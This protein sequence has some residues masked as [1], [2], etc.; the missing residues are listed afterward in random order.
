MSLSYSLA[1]ATLFR[2]NAETAHRLTLKTL[3]A[4]QRLHVLPHRALLDRSPVTYMGLVFPNRV[5]LA[6][7]FD[8]NGDY[9]DALAALGFGFLEIGTVTPEAQ[10][11]NPR[12]RLFRLPAHKA[13]INR[14]GFNN[15][16]VAYL[17]RRLQK[18]HYSGILG[19]NIGKNRST[20]NAR[21]LEDYQLCLQAVYPYASYIT[22]NVSSPNTQ[23]LR[24]LQA[25]DALGDLLQGLTR[26]G[27]QL[28][29]QHGRNVPLMVKIAPDLDE[30][31]IISICRAVEMARFA[32]IVATNTTLDR[33][34]IA[35]HSL[36]LQAGG[37]SGAPLLER[38]NTVLRQVR[39]HLDPALTLIGSGGITRGIDARSKQQAGADLVQ[40]Y[41]GLVYV[42]PALIA[43]IV[44]A[45]MNRVPTA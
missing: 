20:P 43:E 39:K 16:G 7:G 17:V 3:W 23:G 40:V 34:Q 5:G 26:H 44:E 15:K 1:R 42:G 41:S 32:G 9:I 28:A 11:G 22:V 38:S 4:A 19:V 33:T 14:M 29:K 30:D 24:S 8:K 13:I 2:I 37:L 6:A 12:P 35:D 27:A 25:H 21:A 31:E 18:S 36:A 45:M 10:A